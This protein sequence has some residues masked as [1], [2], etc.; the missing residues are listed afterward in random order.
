MVLL[1]ITCVCYRITGRARSLLKLIPTDPFI[2]DALDALG[3]RVSVET[4]RYNLAI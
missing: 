2:S 4:G 3:Q 1:V